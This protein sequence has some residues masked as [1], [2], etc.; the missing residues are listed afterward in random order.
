MELKICTKCNIEK[1]TCDFYKSNK[2]PHNFRTHCKLCMN[3]NSMKNYSNNKDKYL[4]K[5]KEYRQL[6]TE[7]IKLRRKKYLE[8]NPDSFKKWLEKNREHRKNYI[9]NYNSNPLNKMKNS[10]RSR[11]NE[12]MNKK[13]ENPKTIDLLGC[14]YEFFISYIESKFELGMC[15]A[16]Y[17]YRGWHLDHIIPLS[18]AKNENELIKLFHYTNLQPLWSLDNLKKSNKI[19]H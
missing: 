4:A 2:N 11:I 18:S 5:N 13:Y 19:L 9:N 1:P 10:L 3:Q 7:R 12:L 14:N 16:N 15:W 17:G 8:K 6:N